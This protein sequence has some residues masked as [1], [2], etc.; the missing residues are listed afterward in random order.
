MTTGDESKKVHGSKSVPYFTPEQKF[1]AGTPLDPQPK[2]TAIPKLFSPLKIKNVELQNRIG[3]S[4]MCTYSAGLD[5]KPTP[6]HLVHLGQFLMRGPGIT[7]AEASSVAPNGGLSPH[8]LGIWN[9]EQALAFKPIVEFAHSQN[10]LIGAQLAHAGRKASTVPPYIHIEDSSPESAGGW[11][12]NTVAPS[13][14]RFR[15]NGFLPV[16]HELSVAEIK[17]YVKDFGLAAERAL[18]IAGFD[19]IEIH[20]AHGY[21]INEFL[22]EVSN[23]RTDE[24][25][26]SFENRMRFLTEVIEEIRAVT[27]DK[28]PLWLRISASENNDVDPLAW[29]VEDLIRLAKVVREKGVDVLDISSG[30]NSASQSK[31]SKGFGQHVPFARAIKKAVGDSLLLAVPGGLTDSSKVN[32]LVEEGVID[33]ALVARGFL[34]NPGLVATWAEELDIDVQQNIQY[35]YVSHMPKDQI[36]WLIQTSK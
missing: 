31:R 25:G 4:P 36:E 1:R 7:F 35:H 28:I 11:P 20:A 16:P 24:Y 12:Q 14:I 10:Q 22:S 30:G 33:I 27:K 17:E 2:G 34:R 19:I 6:W 23:K 13:P 18:K 26:G 29:T 15:Q 21:L 3:V 8:D 5:G 9:D 32:D